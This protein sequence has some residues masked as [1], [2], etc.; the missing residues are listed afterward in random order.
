MPPDPFQ[1]ERSD[2]TDLIQIAADKRGLPPALVEKNYMR[3]PAFSYLA[4]REGFEPSMPF[5]IH[6]FQ[7]CSFDH[8]DISPNSAFPLFRARRFDHPEI[9]LKPALLSCIAAHQLLRGQG[10][11]AS[12]DI[13]LKSAAPEKMHRQT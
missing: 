6:A 3:K 2:F 1:H 9:S 7:A 11:S 10:R 8:S 5:D 13:D 12:V 4:V